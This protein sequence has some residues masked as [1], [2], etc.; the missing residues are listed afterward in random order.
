MTQGF[1]DRY[2]GDD[3]LLFAGRLVAAADD[4]DRGEGSHAVVYADYALSIVGYQGEAVLYGVEAGLAAV[5]QKVKP[6]PVLPQLGKGKVILLAEFAP[7]LL[8]GLGQHEDDLQVG[9]V[10]TE[11]LNGPH[12]HRPAPNGQKLLRNI[13]P[14]PQALTACHDDY[15]FFTSH[16]IRCLKRMP[17][18]TW[19][20]T[21]GLTS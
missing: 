18:A 14:H 7:V 19:S 20:L 17:S 8:L 15:K 5:G 16:A 1:Y 10:L 9:R 3:G 4:V 2:D 12:Q 6:P 13:S 11:P 21:S